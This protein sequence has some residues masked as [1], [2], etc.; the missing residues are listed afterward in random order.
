MLCVGSGR[1]VEETDEQG[2]FTE[3][4]A[5]EFVQEALE[6]LRWHSHATVVQ[7]AYLALSNEHRLIADVV[8][9][10]GCNINH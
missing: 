3:A 8:C 7:E 2:Q 6:R 4:R 9:F 10:P 1:W 5:G